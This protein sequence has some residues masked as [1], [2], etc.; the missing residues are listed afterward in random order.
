[1][2]FAVTFAG[3]LVALSAAGPAGPAGGAVGSV[4]SVS[5]DNLSEGEGAAKALLRKRRYAEAA[6]AYEALAA[7]DPRPALLIGAGEA[8]AGLGHAAHALDHWRAALAAEGLT[9]RERA[10]LGRKVDKLRGRVAPVRV[11]ASGEEAGEV[12]LELRLGERPPLGRTVRGELEVEL[13]PGEWQARV[14]APGFVPLEQKFR[15]EG[16][17][18]V[19]LGVVRD[20]REV[21]VEL[22]PAA[23]LAVGIVLELR[24]DPEV[25]EVEARRVQ[26]VTSTTSELKLALAPGRWTVRASAPGHLAQELAW[27][28]GGAAPP[29]LVLAGEPAKAPSPPSQRPAAKAAPDL[30]LGLGLGLGLSGGLAFGTGLGTVLR[31]RKVVP[32]FE[33]APDNGGYVAALSAS[34]VGAGLL[35]G[36]LGLGATALTAGFGARD[37]VLWG[38]LAG[39]VTLA[40][41]GAAWYVTEWQ[42][43]QRM[44]Y[45]GGKSDALIELGPVRREL[46]AAALL[47]A[48]VGLA[49]GSGVALLTRKL[50]GRRTRAP[51]AGLDAAG[52]FARF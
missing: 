14:E 35:G 8:R 45:D 24:A 10:E 22:G 4:G 48:G 18:E 38:E 41:A 21:R 7:S 23:A 44:L 29:A 2:A 15:V 17:G 46:G 5:K 9:Q 36:G 32:R 26:E 49:L 16:P 51:R 19:V 1:M 27:D 50:V 28:I 34:T 39:G 25:V 30:R 37:R 42:R 31:Y 33:P 13:D 43:V 20:R 40:I 3:A 6:A 47:G 12:R 11:R 52:F